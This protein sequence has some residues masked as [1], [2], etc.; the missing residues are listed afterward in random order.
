MVSNNYSVLIGGIGGDAHSVGLSILR[1]AL[2]NMGFSV[3][4]LGPQT[5]LEEFCT[6]A[7]YVNAVLMS[8]MDGHAR[9]YMRHFPEMRQEHESEA[10]WY[11]GGNPV[12]DDIA[13]SEK[14]F[15]SMG[16]S[17]VFLKFV[18]ITDVLHFIRR[19][20]DGVVE[21]PLLQEELER[22]ATKPKLES[23]DV[24]DSLVDENDFFALRKEVLEHWRTG[25]QAANMEENA[26][27]LKK[28]SSFAHMHETVH[29]GDAP[30]LIQPRSGVALASEQLKLFKAFKNVGVRCVSYQVDSLTRN[31][32][33]AMAEEAMKESRAAG[34]SVIN[35]FPAVN[36]GV[37]TMRRTVNDLKLPIQMRHSTRDPRLLAEISFA[38]GV[39][40]YEGGAICYNI[41]Y[42]KNYPLTEAIKRWQYVDRLTGI[43]YDKYGILL[44]REYFGTLTAALIP[45]CLAIAT[46]I[47][48]SLLAR[49][50][51]V[52]CVSIGYAEQGHRIQDVAAIRSIGILAHE[53]LANF[54]YTD[55]LINTVYHQYMA[56]FPQLPEQAKQLIQA[57]SVTA[58]LSGATRMLTKTPVESYKIPSLTD[59][60]EGLAMSFRGIDLAQSETVNENAVSEEMKIIRQETLAIID[61]VISFGKGDIARGIVAAFDKGIIDIPFSPSIYN[62]GEAATARD[63]EGAIRFLSCGKLPFD[64]SL[65]QFH[66]EKMT[67]RRRTSGVH[68]NEDYRLIEQDILQVARGQYECWPLT[69]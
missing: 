39:T 61:A 41:P 3:V 47:L 40:G 31:N 42:Y 20:L 57:S 25:I 62:K 51:G 49:Q 32:N 10:K 50:Q 54:G 43:Y 53:V 15:Q 8:C 5:R 69:S 46:G 29:R 19:D 48:E 17:R 56:A 23:S 27:F 38:G 65:K 59:N 45:P 58:K 26:V 67:E 22:F 9:H 12:I 2:T 52:R 13:G 21:K 18:D 14:F 1:R 68:E 30:V 35:G 33:Y 24:N 7:P 6:L 34:Q 64:A 11:L 28:Q 63:N 37:H 36:H 44:D 4:Y 55:V 66:A 16:F 60:L